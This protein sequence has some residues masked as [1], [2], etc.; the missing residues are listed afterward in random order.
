[1]EW[2]LRFYFDNAPNVSTMTVVSSTICLAILIRKVWSSLDPGQV[3]MILPVLSISRCEG[4]TIVD[5]DVSGCSLFAH[6]YA[7]TPKLSESQ[8]E[9]KSRAFSRGTKDTT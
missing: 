6:K 5:N 8:Y 7:G 9:K 2:L 1:M 3:R 4:A